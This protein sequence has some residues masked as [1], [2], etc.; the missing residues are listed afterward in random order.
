MYARTSSCIRINFTL[1][2]WFECNSGV[3][4][5][6]NLSPTLFAVFINDLVG[7]INSLGLGLNINGTPLSMLLYVDDIVLIA[8]SEIDLQQML[9]KLNEW[10]NKWRMLII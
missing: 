7:E 1:T 9:N 4:Q 5:G 3:A 10:C 8:S 6:K 2:S